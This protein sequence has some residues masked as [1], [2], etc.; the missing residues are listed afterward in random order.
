MP[1][2]EHQAWIRFESFEL[3]LQTREL[4]KDGRPIRLQDQPG[5]LLVLLACRAGELV[6][7]AEIEKAL[8]REDEFVE[9]EH[10][11]NTAMRKVREALGDDLERPRFIETLPRKGYRFIAAVE[12]SAATGTQSRSNMDASQP[13]QGLR[14]K[15][16]V[17]SGSAGQTPADDAARAGEALEVAPSQAATLAGTTPAAAE[18]E[19]SLPRSLARLLF[20]TVQGGYLAM[21]CAALYK[22]EAVE[23]VL[24]RVLA[25]AAAIVAPLV[26]VVAMCGIAVRLYLLSSVGL[27]HPAAGEKFQRLFPALFILDTLW[28]VSPLLLVRKI[29]YGLALGAIAALAYLPFSQRTLVLSIYRRSKPPNSNPS[30]EST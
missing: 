8:W 13:V 6:T 1:P 3:N 18:T 29:G 22:A 28:A 25:G 14:S 30:R 12:T 23:E 2:H 19:F 20:L 26:L 16:P 5:K 27:N 4:R 11:V 15:I 9:F 24:A 10:A 7:R 17:R 21:Y